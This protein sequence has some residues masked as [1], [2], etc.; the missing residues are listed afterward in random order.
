MHRS[1]SYPLFIAL[2]VAV[3]TPGLATGEESSATLYGGY[4][5]ANNGFADRWVM[6]SFANF[7][8]GSTGFHSDIVYVNREQ[9]AAFA[10]LGL[11]QALSDRTRIR[12]MAG[13]STHNADIFPSLFLQGSAELKPSDGL[14]LNPSVTYR[15]YRK[16]GSEVAPAVQL[17]RYFK[18]PGD[19]GG[20][21]VAQGD[22]GLSFNSSHRAGWTA[23]AGLSTVRKS[24][25]TLGAGA[26]LGHM[27]YDGGTGTGVRSTFGN[28]NATVGYRFGKGQ[29]IFVRGDVTRSKFYTVAGA[30]VGY[31]V[32]L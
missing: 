24:G 18:I 9:N 11:S 21:Y 23:G 31:K 20:Y 27:A 4:N 6:G 8:M 29:E 3:A 2:T 22:V 19:G 28:G 26:R 16:G 5:I 25:L 14:I 12:F 1:H 10:A 13:S 15:L 17:A 32:P 7:Y 30:M